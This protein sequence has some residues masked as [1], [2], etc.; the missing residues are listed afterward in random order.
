MD[1][2][3][4]EFMN[5]WEVHQS[6]YGCNYIGSLSGME[7]KGAL[8]I[9]EL[10][11]EKYRLRYTS[12]IA[13][14]DSKTYNLIKE[15]KPYRREVE[16]KKFERVRHVQKW[17]GNRILALKKTKLTDDSGRRVQG[18]GVKEPSHQKYH[19]SSVEVL[20]ESDQV[21]CE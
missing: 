1:E 18:E 15:K 6:E 11:V 19:S 17:M 10:S 3:S 7:C 13:D 4:Q 14:G 21:P 8:S 12:L 9:W 5:W 2:T 16:V 20:W